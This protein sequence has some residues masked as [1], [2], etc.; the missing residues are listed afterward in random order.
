MSLAS[1]H[2]D[3]PEVTVAIVSWNTRDLLENC[4]C[5]L[6]DAAHSGLAD[7]WVV[8]NG[9]ADGSRELVKSR[10]P[11]VTLREPA[12]NLGFGRAVNLVADETSSPWLA[13]ANAD[14][15]LRPGALRSL[16][17]TG[18][19]HHRAGCVAP[20][21]VLPTGATQHSVFPFPS[22]ALAAAEQTGLVKAIPGCGDRLCLPGHWD[23]SRAREVPWAVGAFLLVRRTAWDQAGGFDSRQWMYAEDLDLG[24]RLRRA[25]WTCRYEPRAVVMHVESAA[26]DQAFRDDKP[27]RW[28]AATYAWMARRRGIVT[29]WLTALVGWSG[30]AIRLLSGKA[31]AFCGVRRGNA[32]ADRAA[33]WMRMHRTGLR[34][35]RELRKFR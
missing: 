5:S 31:M 13:P 34:S 21:L 11:W 1:A 12:T 15:E 14:L 29:T 17:D 23:A 20:R 35:R 22:V 16:L 24:W 8:D 2:H 9:S 19:R 4:L 7:V 25:G 3:T 30:M 33:F 32:V 6:D 26:T 28:M 18:R 27:L 10:F